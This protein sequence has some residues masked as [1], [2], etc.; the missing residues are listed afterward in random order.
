M[1]APS[2][3]ITRFDLSIAY[4]EFS[5]MANLQKFIGLKVFPPIGVEQEASDF[6]R[7]NVESFLNQR[8]DTRR[9]PYGRYNRSTFDWTKDSYACEEHGVEEVADDALIERYGDIVRVE[10]MAINRA[11]TRIL[12][13]LEYDIATT[14]FNTS[15]WTG[16]TLTA[17]IDTANTANGITTSGNKWT[18]RANSDPLADIDYAAAYV[19]ANCGMAPN[20]VVMTDIDFR[21]CIRSARL[22]GLFKYDAIEILTGMNAGQAS[23]EVVN[24]A[25][26]AL[27]G[28]FQ[29]ERV[30]IGQGWQNTA[31]LGQTAVFARHWTAGRVM[32]C[33]VNNDG[34][35]GDLESVMPN[36]GRTI[37]ST[38]NSEP[39]PGSDDAG[40]G[41]LIFDEYREEQSRG[42]IFRPR[43]KRQVKR[44][45]TEAGFLLT[46]AQ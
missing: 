24:T 4:H 10:Q 32:V 33:H 15:T 30:L 37:F 8:E 13:T 3:A 2:T 35:S 19:K 44:L 18:D 17:D 14:V 16:S 34:M 21:N 11:V 20:T 39:L 41:S 43:N 29:V 6:L 42:S 5:L 46:G 45:H 7:I 40:F 31:D 23:T 26:A 25:A 1:A 22:E 38:K 28:A 27:A 9:A 36:I 12:Q